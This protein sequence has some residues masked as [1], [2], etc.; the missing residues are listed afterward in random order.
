MEQQSAGRHIESYTPGEVLD[1]K[2]L[3][4]C[5]SDFTNLHLSLRFPLF[6]MTFYRVNVYFLFVYYLK[7]KAQVSLYRSPDIN[8]PS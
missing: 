3:H 4:E 7:Q 8:K 6:L 1:H 2:T 5:V